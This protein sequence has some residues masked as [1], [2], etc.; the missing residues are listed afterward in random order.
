MRHFEE[1]GD[2]VY[3]TLRYTHFNKSKI[4]WHGLEPGM[5]AE[6]SVSK[7]QVFLLSYVLLIKELLKG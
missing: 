4:P 6:K 3:G 7:S 1:S 2:T 5:S